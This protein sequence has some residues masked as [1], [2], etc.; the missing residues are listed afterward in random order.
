MLPKKKVKHDVYHDTIP[1]STNLQVS[2][3]PIN[4]TFDLNGLNDL[5]TSN[6]CKNLQ[7]KSKGNGRQ[8]CCPVIN[9]EKKFSSKENLQNHMDMMSHNSC[10]PSKSITDSFSSS[11]IINYICPKCGQEFKFEQ[12]CLKHQESSK[13]NAFIKPI[14]SS[15]YIC[16]TC[17]LIF[18]SKFNCL[19]H[20]N[21]RRHYLSTFNFQMSSEYLPVPLPKVLETDFKKKC[22][23]IPNDIM[24][25]SCSSFLYDP[26]SIIN[27]INNHHTVECVSKKSLK[28]IFSN[29]FGDV[30]CSSCQQVFHKST[31]RSIGMKHQCT[32]NKSGVL[33]KNTCKSFRE[34]VLR[35]SLNLHFPNL[36]T[37][38]TGLVLRNPNCHG[39]NSKTNW[40]EPSKRC[41]IK[42]SVS[43]SNITCNN[44]SSTQFPFSSKQ[45]NPPTI[46]SAQDLDCYREKSEFINKLSR[47]KHIIFLDLDNWRGIF[48]HVQHYFPTETFLWVFRGA[49]TKWF[50]PKSDVYEKLVQDGCFFL[51]PKSGCTK[52]AADF[53]LVLHVG[54]MDERLPEHIKFTILSGVKG[55]NEVCHQLE[56]SKRHMQI[57]DP[58]HFTKAS[59]NS[60]FQLSQA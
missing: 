17:L 22:E 42:A 21:T 6:S 35:S 14:P 13:H 28:D 49:Q 31:N 39:D 58:H 9:C 5:F 11:K 55:F 18:P 36:L 37:S 16:Q 41:K 38:S 51:N 60:L 34:L 48:K 44:K 1:Q 53:A 56:N 59:Y 26:T 43:S 30:T 8:I 27:H 50:P 24:C 3:N 10:N 15:S 54:K 32:F 52:Q 40:E 57:V 7:C 46:W 23:A 33:L 47:M 4:N 19:K 12:M 45:F 29:Y 25:T 2:L 20:M